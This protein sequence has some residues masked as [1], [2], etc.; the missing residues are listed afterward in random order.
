M[1]IC[2]LL[3]VVVAILQ[4]EII[5]LGLESLPFNVVLGRIKMQKQESKW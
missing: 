5:C 3:F 2:Q 1:S 4:F